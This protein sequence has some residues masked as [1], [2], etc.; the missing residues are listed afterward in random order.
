MAI[1]NAKLLKSDR[2]KRVFNILMDGN[3]H[4]TRDLIRK[5]RVC[6]VNQIISEL[7]ANAIGIN[8]ERRQNKWFY[9]LEK[10][11]CVTGE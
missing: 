9:W 4:T 1:H 11:E 8:C 3:Q 2:L 6:A 5:A 10:N 7:R